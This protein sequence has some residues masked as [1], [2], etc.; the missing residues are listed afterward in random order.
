MTTVAGISGSISTV[1]GISSSVVTVAGNIAGISAAVAALGFPA[2]VANRRGAMIA[3]NA[4]DNGFEFL[5]QGSAGQFLQSQGA[6]ALPVFSALP[7]AS[8]TVAGAVEL[9]TAAETTTGADAARAVTP[10]GLAGSNFGKAVV[11]I[12][13]FDD[14]STVTTGDGKRY[15]IAP[16]EL[17]GYNLVAAHA[18]NSTASSSGNPTIQ[19][20]N[21]RHAQDVLSAPITIDSGEYSSYTAATPPAINATYDD[22]ATGDASG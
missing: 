8:D 3:Q 15:F 18:T 5:P 6:D 17:N 14:S 10:D 13:V 9:A 16:Q 4:A 7:A 22:V 11:A 1:A 2:F 19:V 12:G 20:H 21:L